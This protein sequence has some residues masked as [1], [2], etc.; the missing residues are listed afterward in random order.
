MIGDLDT[1]MSLRDRAEFALRDH[2]IAEQARL[3]AEEDE[4]REVAW[5]ILQERLE[6]TEREIESLPW[7]RQVYVFS[8]VQHAVMHFTIDDL[9]FSLRKS[10]Y[11][12]D[13]PK[14]ELKFRVRGSEITIETLADLGKRLR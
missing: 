9:T 8:S 2:E 10:P 4:L 1:K 6:L 13:H 5:E 11:V 7:E 12:T 14:Y 3:Q